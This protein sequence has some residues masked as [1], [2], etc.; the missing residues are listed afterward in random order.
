MALSISRLLAVGNYH[1]SFERLAPTSA[2]G[3]TIPSLILMAMP[4]GTRASIQVSTVA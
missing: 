1:F 4:L 2:G 3:F